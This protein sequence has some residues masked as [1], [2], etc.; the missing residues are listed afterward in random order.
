MKYNLE[1]VYKGI[2]T[3]NDEIE[4]GRLWN[5]PTELSKRLVR[6]SSYKNYLGGYLAEVTTKYR[7]KKRSV[8]LDNRADNKSPNASDVEATYQT[9]DLKAEKE[10]LQV[11]YNTVKDHI[12]A[13]QTHLS[14]LRSERYESEGK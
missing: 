8:Y 11:N 5:Q 6:L 13:I 9:Q 4:Q 3:V 14:T 12:S 1:E 2:Q 7:N 10:V